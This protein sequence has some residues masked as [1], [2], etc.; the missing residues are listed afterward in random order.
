[1]SRRR[2]IEDMPRLLAALGLDGPDGFD[3]STVEEDLLTERERAGLEHWVPTRD[4][5]DRAVA[6]PRAAPARRSRSS[7]DTF[8]SRASAPEGV[9]SQPPGRHRGPLPPVK[10]VTVP[11]VLRGA[12]RRVSPRVLAVALVIVALATLVFA[13]RV[14]RARAAEAPRPVGPVGTAAGPDRNGAPS[15]GI[16]SRTATAFAPTGASAGPTG[17]TS[18]RAGG[19]AAGSTAQLVVVHVVGQVRKPG[20]VRLPTGSRV[21]DAVTAAGGA[22][23][24][25]DLAALNLARVLL[26]GEQV[27]VPRPGEVPA[28]AS[29]PV[30]TGSGSGEAGPGASPGA[31]VN[32]NTADLST[33]DTLPGVGPVLAQRILDWRAEHGR[34]SSI[35]ELG[36]VSGIGEKM[37][38][39]LTPKVTV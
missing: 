8:A 31:R 25:A 24:R 29:G 37:L 16:V 10:V 22:T 12:R 4:S 17:P 33:L 34:F 21:A 7:A 32:L 28:A 19:P 13:A 18:A 5:L 38:A 9:A 35:D 27:R 23:S 1:M 3:R 30:G 20:I 14:V 39:Q 15:T 36:E 6:A 11:S 2:D 26:D